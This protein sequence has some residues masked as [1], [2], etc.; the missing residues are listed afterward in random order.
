[1]RG[2]GLGRIQSAIAQLDA[3]SGDSRARRRGVERFHFPVA[4]A[5][6]LITVER[7]IGTRRRTR[8]VGSVAQL[9]PIASA[10][11]AVA[12]VISYVPFA[13][14][15]TNDTTNT[16]VAASTGP[17]LKSAR[18]FYNAGTRK[19]AEGKLAD[20]ESLFQSALT[21]QE[22][23]VRPLALYNL[24]QARFAQGVEALE[25]EKASKGATTRAH[26]ALTSGAKAIQGAQSALAEKEM[27]KMVSAY[28]NGRGARKE[29]RE[30]M[31]AVQRAMDV[32]AT[33]LLKWRR[34]LGD[35]RSAAELNP[36]DTNAVQNVKIVEQAIAKLVDS[37]REMMQMGQAM[38]QQS[39]QLKELLNQLKGQIPMENMPPG[40]PGDDGEEDEKGKDGEEVK[41]ESL[42]GQEESKGQEGREMEAPLSPEE[43]GRLLDGF[44]LDGG[45]R[46]P[47][48]GRDPGFEKEGKNDKRPSRP[49]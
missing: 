27:Q 25:K 19:L 15:A 9:S 14:A 30:A 6:L 1:M 17:V 38:S 46:L 3:A 23:Q 42:T 24:G 32:H 16:I 39:P 28:L 20:A 35:F 10:A 31:K 36:A 5:L 40:A 44:R 8:A 41:P 47:M 2:D 7:L 26:S 12:G 4:L 29:L 33:A 43:A 13:G 37:L 22:E 49:W 45:R 48:S 34:S 21:T 11:L 18:E